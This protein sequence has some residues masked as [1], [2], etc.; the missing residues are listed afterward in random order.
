MILMLTIRSMCPFWA[1]RLRLPRQH[2]GGEAGEAVDREEGQLCGAGGGKQ[3]V[4]QR[5]LLREAAARLG[6]A[7]GGETHGGGQGED[8]F[9]GMLI[10]EYGKKMASGP[11]IGIADQLQKVM[12]QM[13]QQKR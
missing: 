5:A 10:Q 11:G 8:M 1:Q 9:R 2:E 12:I 4:G 6:V 7:A 3:G 13:Q